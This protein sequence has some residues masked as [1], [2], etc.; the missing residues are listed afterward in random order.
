VGRIVPLAQCKMPFLKLVEMEEYQKGDDLFKFK[1]RISSNANIFHPIL[2]DRVPQS[3]AFA[4][5]VKL[6]L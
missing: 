4:V 6:K 5:E 3:C 2:I 1:L